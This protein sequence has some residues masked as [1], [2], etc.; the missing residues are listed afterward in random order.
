MYKGKHILDNIKDEKKALDEK[1]RKPTQSTQTFR[2]TPLK[3][4]TNNSFPTPPATKKSASLRLITPRRDNN[5]NID[6][7]LYKPSK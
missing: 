7:N 6:K 3:S 4:L 1:K 2:K 5:E